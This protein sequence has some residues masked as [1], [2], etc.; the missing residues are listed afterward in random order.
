MVKRI[1]S[2]I[3]YILTALLV[4]G[5]VAYG[6]NRLVGVIDIMGTFSIHSNVEMIPSR[7]QVDLGIIDAPQGSKTYNNIARL[8]VRNSTE[9][10]VRVETTGKGAQAGT[11]LSVIIAG[12]LSLEGGGRSYSIAMP[13]LYTNT[14]CARILI[15]IPG[16]DAPMPI[17]KGEYNVS[18]ELSWTAEGTGEVPVELSIQVIE[19]G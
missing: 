2:G 18:L 11:G 19:A 8:V 1:W 4:V 13:C 16:Y 3:L 15:L 14:E 10:I 6:L 7:V 9:I 17:E 5:L 12:R